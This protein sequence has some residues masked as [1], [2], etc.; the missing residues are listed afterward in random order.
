MAGRGDWP[1]VPFAT[2]VRL[3]TDRVADPAAA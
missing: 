3:N 2:V 1:T